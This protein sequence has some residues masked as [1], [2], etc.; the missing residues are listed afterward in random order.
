MPNER[1]RPRA[2]RRVELLPR[3]GAAPALLFGLVAA[4]VLGR[5]PHVDQPVR[6]TA[7][8]TAAWMNDWEGVREI[9]TAALAAAAP[10]VV[11]SIDTVPADAAPRP[12]V[13]AEADRPPRDER[14]MVPRDVPEPEYTGSFS[15]GSVPKAPRS[16]K[17]QP[18]YEPMPTINRSGKGDR[19]LSP[20]PL[21]RSTEQDLMVKPTLAVVPPTQEGWPP[22]MRLASLTAPESEK[23]LP[24]LALAKPEGDMDGRVVVALVRSGPGRVVTPSVIAQLAAS[25]RARDRSRP[26]LPPMPD[27]HLAAANP[28]TTV[29]AQPPVPEMAYGR[30]ND[31]EARFRA[32]LG[33]ED[34][35][36]AKPAPAAQS[37]DDL[38]P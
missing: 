36:V 5:T 2:P 24:R 22:L 18:G 25:P 29:W 35:A 31:I 37:D 28:R 26:M 27:S 12:I 30:R 19:L 3:I 20:Q 13:V 15:T 17:F 14:K 6:W 34:G 1:R 16:E 33:D 7:R 10:T 21:G 11:A 38:P 9:R 8:D 4:T 23:T 32:V